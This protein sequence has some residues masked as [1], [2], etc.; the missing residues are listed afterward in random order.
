MG[1]DWIRKTLKE[2]R[3]CVMREMR[4]RRRFSYPLLETGDARNCW[5]LKQKWNF[6]AIRMPPLEG[7]KKQHFLTVPKSL[8]QSR[9]RRIGRSVVPYWGYRVN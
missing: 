7:A 9:S 2:L 6:S 8:F 1:V 4:G 5:A 3:I